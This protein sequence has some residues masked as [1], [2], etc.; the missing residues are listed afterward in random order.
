MPQDFQPGSTADIP[1]GGGAGS[2]HH[3]PGPASL[4]FV[5]FFF[6]STAAGTFSTLFNSPVDT[7]QAIVFNHRKHVEDNGMACSDCHEHYEKETFSGLPAADLCSFCH[8]EALGESA[9]ELKLVELLEEGA[10]L[11]WKPLFRQPPH[12]FYS[13]RRHVA[14]AELECET[15]HGSFA[16]TEAPPARVEI[17]TMEVCLDCHLEEGTATDCTACH[18]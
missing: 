10:P 8:A 12:V 4:G 7:E 13:H 2:V 14:V 1:S 11:E 18:R 16:E 3:G 17:M 5:L 9:E 15:C 6:L